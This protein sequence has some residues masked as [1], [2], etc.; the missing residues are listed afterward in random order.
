MPRP[1]SVP[2]T[3][4][5][6]IEL[7]WHTTASKI[8]SVKRFSMWVGPPGAGKTTAAIALSRR[9]NEKDPL[10]IQGTPG[11]ESIDLWGHYALVGSET[12]FND[13]PLTQ[14][15]KEGRALV[16]EEFNLIPPGVRAELLPLRALDRV[17]VRGSNELIE[18]PE[19]WRL[20]ATCNPETIGCRHDAMATLAVQDGFLI[21]H[22]PRTSPEQMAQMLDANFPDAGAEL[23]ARVLKLWD[24]YDCVVRESSID[25]KLRLS[26]RAAADLLLLLEAG[27]AEAAA[28]ECA[29]VNKYTGDDDALE[30]ARLHHAMSAPAGGRS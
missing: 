15:L 9:L 7:S 24:D 19:G 26:Y 28:I 30:A 25:S 29:L 18:V 1:F 21:T 16:L 17:R 10:I 22:I 2:D 3:N 5:D 23:I 13:G 27:M 14:S 4:P 6:F 8:L 12:R 20:I 11:I